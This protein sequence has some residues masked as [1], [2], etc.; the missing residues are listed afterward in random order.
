MDFFVLHQSISHSAYK[1]VLV[2]DTD[3]LS[4]ASGQH[5][6]ARLLI[7]AEARNTMVRLL[8]VPKG[9]GALLPFGPAVLAEDGGGHR[10][11][12]WM[13]DSP[14]QSPKERGSGDQQAHGDTALGGTSGMLT[15]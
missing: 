7:R 15:S 14:Y 1:T 9:H 4:D 12:E 6:A 3:W 8:R 2:G 11:E 10:G 13:G 5:W